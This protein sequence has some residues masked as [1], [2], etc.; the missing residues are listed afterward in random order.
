VI[1]NSLAVILSKTLP[2][3]FEFPMATWYLLLILAPIAIV[4]V[5][6]QLRKN[7]VP[8]TS[9]AEEISVEDEFLIEA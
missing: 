7:S 5:L 4:H 2:A 8:W 1:N 3:N 6:K 9:I